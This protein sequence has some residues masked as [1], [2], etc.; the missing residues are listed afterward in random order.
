MGNDLTDR[1]V[2]IGDEY[3]QRVWTALRDVLSELGLV[4]NSE[5]WGVGGSQE[6]ITIVVS[7]GSKTLTIESET[8]LGVSVAGEPELVAEVAA[9]VAG[10]L[11]KAGPS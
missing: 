9:R 7:A 1:K 2:R 5:E 10:R 4:V 8:Y 3:D 11:G 6:L